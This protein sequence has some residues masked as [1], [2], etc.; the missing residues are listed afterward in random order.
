MSLIILSEWILTREVRTNSG[1][2]CIHA[3]IHLVTHF[4]PLIISLL[5]HF[6]AYVKLYCQESQEVSEQI[7]LWNTLVRFFSSMNEAKIGSNSASS[8]STEAGVILDAFSHVNLGVNSMHLLTITTPH[9]LP[10]PHSI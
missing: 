3:Y 9:N 10:Q 8:Y 2:D 5:R 1:T 4:W 7:E 6:G